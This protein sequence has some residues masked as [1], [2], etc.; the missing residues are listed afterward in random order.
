L[1]KVP[2]F[3]HLR[4]VPLLVHAH[5]RVLVAVEPAFAVTSLPEVDQAVVVEEL[6]LSHAHLLVE[7]AVASCWKNVAQ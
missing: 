7:G 6:V 5:L 2:S 3:D 4:Q 1:L